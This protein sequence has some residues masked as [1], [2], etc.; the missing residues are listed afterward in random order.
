MYHQVFVRKHLFQRKKMN[1]KSENVDF[2]MSNLNINQKNPV[3]VN[4]HSTLLTNRFIALFDVWRLISV[5]NLHI[6]PMFHRNR[7]VRHSNF[8]TA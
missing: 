5:I 4:V 8:R 2:H 7:F 3:S 1:A 6:S